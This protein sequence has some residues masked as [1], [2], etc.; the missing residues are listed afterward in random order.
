MLDEGDGDHFFLDVVE[1]ADAGVVD[2]GAFEVEVLFVFLVEH[3]GG[4]IG[5]VSTG[6]ALAS[7]VDTEVFDAKKHLEIFEEVD[8]I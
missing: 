1:V 7:D 2:E 5:H 3:G 8:E 6:V 4:D